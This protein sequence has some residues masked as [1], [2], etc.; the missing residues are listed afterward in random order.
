M[1]TL[2]SLGCAGLLA[3][4][5]FASPAMAKLGKATSPSVVAET[6]A[7]GGLKITAKT[8]ELRV[9]EN[10]EGTMVV[11]VALRNLDTGNS[12]RNK[13]LREKYLEVDKYPDAELSIPRSSLDFPSEPG[14]TVSHSASGTMKLHGVSRPATFTYSAKKDGAGY[15]VTGSTRIDIRDYGI[16]TPS[17]MGVTVQPDVTVS[18]GFAVS[19]S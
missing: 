6:S 8:S 2:R 10:P 7:T 5:L 13:H 19:D 14:R 4:A 17:F 16:Q 3:M 9:D 1:K 11:I 15:S 12:L 18:V